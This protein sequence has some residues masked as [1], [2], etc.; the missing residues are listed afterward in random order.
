MAIPA[1]QASLFGPALEPFGLL[2][3][4]AAPERP[5]HPTDASAQDAALR[6]GQAYLATLRHGRDLVRGRW[7]MS[8]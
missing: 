2:A 7:V 1:I 5:Y 3:G 6:D 4:V 8:V